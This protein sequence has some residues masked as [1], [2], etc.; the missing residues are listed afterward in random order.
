VLTVLWTFYSYSYTQT[1]PRLN[2]N[3]SFDVNTSMVGLQGGFSSVADIQAGFNN[4]RR[5]EESQFCIRAN[6]IRNLSM[7]SQAAWNAMTI[8]EKFIFLINNERQW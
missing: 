5:A 6:S 4:A 7:P 8:D 3:I 1:A 2:T